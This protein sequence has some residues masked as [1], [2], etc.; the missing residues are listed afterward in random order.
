MART[1]ITG[2]QIKDYSVDLTVDVTGVLP[3]SKGGTGS[4]TSP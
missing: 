4:S 2:S 3:I 1:E